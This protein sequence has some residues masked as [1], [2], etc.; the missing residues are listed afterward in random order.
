[1][2]NYISS[3]GFKIN[4]T[5]LDLLWNMVL[6]YNLIINPNEIHPFESIKK[7]LTISQKKTLYSFLSKNI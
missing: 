6:E 2:V 4:S 7:K 5:S 3:V 1:M